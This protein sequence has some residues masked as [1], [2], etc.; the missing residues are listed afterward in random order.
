M[1]HGF[2]SLTSAAICQNRNLDVISNNMV[3]VSTPGY[4]KDTFLSTSFQEEL[5]T[6]TSNGQGKSFPIG[7]VT[8]AKVANGVQ[9]N[10]S[11]GTYETT[12]GVFD[13][14]LTKPGF[15]QVQGQNGIGYT[16]NGSFMLNAEGYLAIKGGGLVLGQ[17]GPIYLGTDQIYV[18]SQGNIYNENTKEYVDKLAIVDFVDYSQIKKNK[19]GTLRCPNQGIPTDG[20]VMWKTLE[21]A[22]V[23][24]VEEMTSMMSSQRSIQ[25]SAQII[26]LYDQLMGKVVSEIGRI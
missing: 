20:G 21:K 2:Y 14:A 15:F 16:R 24:M 17:N 5:M 8:M 19:D 18:D 1:F 23:D 4:K 13:F 11:Q 7:Q 9:T 12:E 25:S 22:N 3:N 10:F 6:R 26:K